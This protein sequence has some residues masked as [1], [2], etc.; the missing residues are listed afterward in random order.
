[1]ADILSKPLTTKESM[2]LMKKLAK[3]NKVRLTNKH[4]KPGAIISFGYNAKNQLDTF[5]KTPLAFILMRGK[6]H[7][8]AINFHWAPIPMRVVLAKAI[9]MA[10]KN[11]IKNKLPLV[12]DY[13]KLKPLL[14]KIGFAPVIR[15]YINKR[16]T[17]GGVIIPDEHILNAARLKTETF[18]QGRVD[19]E[20][21]YKIALR[22]NKK[23]R[24]ER[25]RRQ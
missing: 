10:N 7:T 14:R 20:T 2:D 11:N 23:Y 22:K 17:A 25:K 13:K 1:M 8:L 21:L 12:F 16:I 9:I 5:D 24:Q 3:S 15:L 19:A 18:T 4:F 6:T